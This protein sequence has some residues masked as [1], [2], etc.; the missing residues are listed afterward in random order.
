MD[1]YTYTPEDLGFAGFPPGTLR[2]VG[3]D[4]IQV[5]DPYKA[6]VFVI[7]PIIRHVNWAQVP[8]LLTNETRHVCFNL[9]EDMLLDTPPGVLAFR[10]DCTKSILKRNPSTVSWPWPCQDV[11]EEVGSPVIEEQLDITFHGWVSS[12]ICETA[13]HSIE[14]AGLTHNIRRD[15]RFWGISVPLDERPNLRDGFLRAMKNSLLTLSVRSV[16]DGV[17]RYR[18]YESMAMGRPIVHVNDGA[19]YPLADRID[20]ARFVIRIPERDAK[21]TGDVVK[22]YLEMH[23]MMDILQAGEYARSMWLRWLDSRKWP[24]TMTEIVREKLDL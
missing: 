18:F 10:C 21:T 19:V 12:P 8:Y 23:S 1:V 5:H 4:V 22:D 13:V 11:L 15:N 9:A 20:Y 7:P 17:I 6:D 2:L 3:D 14:K 16:P 24:E